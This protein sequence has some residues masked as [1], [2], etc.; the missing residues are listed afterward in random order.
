MAP[1]SGPESAS[2]TKPLS[3]TKTS[4]CV[5]EFYSD[6]DQQQSRNVG[7]NPHLP[8]GPTLYIRMMILHELE[9]SSSAA[10]KCT[11][12]YRLQREI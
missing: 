6:D 1:N 3:L 7:S 4:D 10:P 8:A 9:V 2:P 12:I 5:A 11:E